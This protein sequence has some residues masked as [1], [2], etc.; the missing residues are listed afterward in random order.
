MKRNPAMKQV[1]LPGAYLL[2]GMS[3]S[4]DW[5]FMKTLRLTL[6]SCFKTC[7]AHQKKNSDAIKI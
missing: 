1:R 5:Q 6:T 7:R 3:E 4:L 2:S